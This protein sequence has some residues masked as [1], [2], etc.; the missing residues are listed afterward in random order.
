MTESNNFTVCSQIRSKLIIINTVHC[1]VYS[2]QHDITIEL[3]TAIPNDT[4][5]RYLPTDPLYLSLSSSLFTGD[6]VPVR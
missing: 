5:K 2:V 3:A 4:L 6:K 1:T